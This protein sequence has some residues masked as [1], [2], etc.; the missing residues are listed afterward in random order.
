M[1]T[2][3]KDNKGKVLLKTA[4]VIL[5]ILAIPFAA[6]HAAQP[7]KICLTYGLKG[8][9]SDWRKKNIVAVEMA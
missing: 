6:A 9:W 5:M 8:M 4:F 7:L 1:S 3:K 2:L